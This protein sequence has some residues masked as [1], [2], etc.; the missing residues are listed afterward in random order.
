MENQP[1]QDRTLDENTFDFSTGSEAS[2]RV[3]IE[4]RIL[5]EDEKEEGEEEHIE[6]EGKG[7]EGK[8]T[9]ENSKSDDDDRGEPME[10]DGGGQDQDQAIDPSTEQEKR[11]KNSKMSKPPKK[12]SHLLKSITID[13]PEQGGGNNND[14]LHHHHHQ[15]QQ[16]QSTQIEWRKPLLPPTTAPNPPSAS[17]LAA[18]DFDALFFE[19]KSD[20]NIP[21]TIN[22]VLDENPERF[23]LSPELARL[24]DTDE[25]DRASVVLGVWDYIK[26][27]QLQEDDERRTIRCDAALKSVFHRDQIYFPHIPDHLSPH[28]HPLAPIQLPYTIRVDQAYHTTMSAQDRYTIYD[29]PLHTTSADHN[30]PL[31]SRMMKLLQ[32]SH[33]PHPDA[34]GLLRVMN[35]TDDQLATLVQAMN[36]SRAKHAFFV[37]MS[38]NP[39]TFV[40]RWLGSQK[41]DLSVILGESNAATRREMNDGDGDGVDGSDDAGMV[42]GGGG[43][44]A[45]GSRNGVWTSQEVRELVG[46]WLAR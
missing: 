22:I 44:A 38:K 20:E 32:S 7:N 33:P 42:V 9:T 4:G 34:V 37:E 36:Q 12:F 26:T 8:K 16:S 1:W 25:G 41:R 10:H 39:V 6:D 15:Q 31:R 17:I 3:R 18:A 27:V 19:R 14:T 40:R 35:A 29:I 21:I 46:L 28:L 24:L 45:G 13:F 11:N 43:V 23:R 2:Y 5:D 30:D